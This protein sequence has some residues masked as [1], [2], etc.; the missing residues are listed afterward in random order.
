MS[1]TIIPFTVVYRSTLVISSESRNGHA[2][3]D[4]QQQQLHAQ[5]NPPRTRPQR[6]KPTATRPKCSFRT[7]GVGH[8]TN[9]THW[10]IDGKAHCKRHFDGFWDSHFVED[11]RVV[12]LDQG[13]GY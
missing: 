1:A 13:D 9:R 7:A 11:H 4:N 2:T 5:S 8:C 6:F 3:R 12:R 10:L